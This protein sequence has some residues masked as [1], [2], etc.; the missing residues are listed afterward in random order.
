MSHF[1]SPLFLLLTIS[2]LGLEPFQRLLEAG[3][4]K[5][6]HPS[7]LCWH[8][9]ILRGIPSPSPGLL[10][11]ALPASFSGLKHTTFREITSHRKSLGWL[12]VLVSLFSTLGIFMDSYFHLSF[13]PVPLPR[14]QYPATPSQSLE[15]CSEGGEWLGRCLALVV[16]DLCQLEL[17]P[18][19]HS[20]LQLHLPSVDS[21]GITGNIL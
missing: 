7:S 16:K 15:T 4:Q 12:L 9:A 10:P 21:L 5:F 6:F 11:R 18:F 3:A 14:P 19:W 13:L 20:S 2:E 17:L 1:L 8:C